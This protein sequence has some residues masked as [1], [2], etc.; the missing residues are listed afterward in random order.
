[1]RRMIFIVSGILLLSKQV[2]NAKTNPDATEPYLAVAP[3]AAAKA[4]MTMAMQQPQTRKM[5][6]DSSYLKL[7]QHPDYI[8]PKKALFFSVLLPG[9]G[10][11]YCKEYLRSL[12]FIGVEASAWAVYYSYNQKGKDKENEFETFADDN[13]DYDRYH[14]WELEWDPDPENKKFSH[15]IPLDNN[16]R[17]VKTQQYYEM[18]GKYDQFLVGWEGVPEDLS[19]N[20]EDANSVYDYIHQPREHYMDMRYDANQLLKN[21]TKGVYLAMFNRIASAIDAAWVAKRHNRTI[22]TSLRMENKFYDMQPETVLT[23]NVAW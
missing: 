1:M 12:V 13:W 6:P 9:A 20:K 5:G 21:A 15:S 7:Q 22:V 16:G 18:I 2:T 3:M 19:A 14:T 10:E 11:L 4:E 17:P 8:L 23:L